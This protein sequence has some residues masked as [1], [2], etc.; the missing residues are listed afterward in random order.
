M[1]FRELIFKDFLVFKGENR[2][3]FPSPDKIASSL[4]LILAPNSGGKTSVI[5][6]LEFLLYGSLRREMPATLDELINKSYVKSVR[7]D[8]RLEAWVQA[9]IEL[10][11]EV[12]TIRRRIETRRTPSASPARVVLEQIVHSPKGDVF[13]VD[14]GRIQRTLDNLV[15]QSLFD[16]FYFQGETLAQQLLQGSGDQ[17][18]PEGL[19]TLLHED[20]WED[21]ITTVDKVRRQ[22]SNEIQELTAANIEYQKKDAAREQVKDRIRAAQAAIKDYQLQ[23]DQAQTDYDNAEKQIKELGTEKSHQ[24]I[25]TDLNRKRAEAKGAEVKFSQIEGRICALV[26]ESKGLPFYQDAFE[27]ALKHLEQMK[28]ENLLPADVSDGFVS[29]LLG[30]SHCICGRPLTPREEFATERSCIEEYGKRTLAADLNAGLLSLLNQLDQKIRQNFYRQIDAYR[31]EGR[32]LLGERGDTIL[33]QHELTEAIKDLEAQRAKSN[34]DAIVQQQAKQREAQQRLSHAL[35]EAKE[36]E[37]LIRNLEAQEKQLTREL[38]EMGRR[39]AGPYILKLDTMRE[40]ANA[41]QLLIE[42]SLDLLKSSFHTL[43]QSS[44][45][46]YYDPKANDNSQAYI[47]P[48]TLLPSIKRNGK[49]LHALGGGQR[50]MLVLAHIISLAELRRNLHAQ[51]DELGI[52]TGKLDDQSFFLDSIFAPCDPAYARDVAAFLPGKARQMMLLVARQQ[53]YQEIQSEIEPHVHKVFTMRLYSN[54]QD[55]P[56]EEYVFAFKTRRLNLF[57]KIAVDE[58]PYSIIEEVK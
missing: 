54:N 47:D 48:K 34:I 6:A 30:G 13:K 3:T 9:K 33:L 2:I 44:V 32:S 49:T 22:L 57:T 12:A 43:L 38:N 26:A 25:T 52:K 19:A 55:R 31:N 24:A 28:Q 46:K 27:P 40:R 50:Q 20:K 53:W 23:K 11:G 14:E 51:L 36:L 17:A 5:R 18:I 56:P 29:R 41:L 7:I 42:Q 39:G 8:S 10:A 35:G 58:E 37:M 15:P 21:A 45:A 16:Y 1:L 4:V